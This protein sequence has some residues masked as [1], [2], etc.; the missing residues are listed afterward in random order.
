VG[1]TNLHEVLTHK[2]ESNLM[3]NYLMGS[4]MIILK[5]GLLYLMLVLTVYLTREI[6]LSLGD[7]IQQ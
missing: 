6:D 7:L 2:I 4:L 5:S 1:L 3:F